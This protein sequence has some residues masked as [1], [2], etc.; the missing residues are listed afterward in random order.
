MQL[1]D[2]VSIASMNLASKL[3]CGVRK[4]DSPQVAAYFIEIPFITITL[5]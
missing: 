5:C 4:P 3:V 2:A 1:H